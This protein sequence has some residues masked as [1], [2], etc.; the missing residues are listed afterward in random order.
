MS[1]L[2]CIFADPDDL[3]RGVDKQS[4][5][6]ASLSTTHT[7]TIHERLI[8]LALTRSCRSCIYSARP[9][10]AAKRKKRRLPS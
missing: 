6:P 2:L 5:G 3:T 10:A 9:A 7:H 4:L 1:A 8:T